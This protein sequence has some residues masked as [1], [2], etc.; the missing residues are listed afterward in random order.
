MNEKFQI[1]LEGKV[2]EVIKPGEKCFIKVSCNPFLIEL[3]C[4]D[5]NEFRLEDII[6]LNC[7][8]TIKRLMTKEEFNQK[9]T[10]KM[11]VQD[12]R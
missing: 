5:V 12:E 1:N 3:P 9:S 8:I 7:E 2:L 10:N 4:P 6:I 11:E